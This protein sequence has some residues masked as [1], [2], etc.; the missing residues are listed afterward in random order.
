MISLQYVPH[1][2]P[3]TL[4]WHSEVDALYWS[5]SISKNEVERDEGNCRDLECCL[6]NGSPRR[7]EDAWDAE[8]PAGFWRLLHQSAVEEYFTNM[9]SILITE[10][11]VTTQASRCMR[12]GV[13]ARQWK[14]CLFDKTTETPSHATRQAMELCVWNRFAVSSWIHI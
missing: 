11:W 4:D 14:G 2:T 8:S 12:S 10:I 6:R 5:R 1:W 13:H 9:I 3:V 7:G